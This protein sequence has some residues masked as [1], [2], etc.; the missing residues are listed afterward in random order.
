MRRALAQVARSHGPDVLG[1]SLLSS[2]PAVPEGGMFVGPATFRAVV[3]QENTHGFGS[4]VATSK[5][6]ILVEL[7]L[8]ER[9]LEV[10]LPLLPVGAPPAGGATAAEP[11]PAPAAEFATPGRLAQAEAGEA[12]NRDLQHQ[13]CRAVV[14]RLSE[15]EC[16]PRRARPS[17]R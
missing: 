3:S 15:S 7:G 11:A 5:R 9:R 10:D 17:T 14:E 16:R 2:D 4:E 1:S 8:W 6:R 12:V 13:I